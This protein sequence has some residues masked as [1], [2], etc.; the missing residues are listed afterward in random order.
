MIKK[1]ILFSLLAGVLCCAGCSKN[2]DNDV[3]PRENITDWF[4]VRDKPG[5][6]N[7][8]L[9]KVY[10]EHGLAI[11]INDTLGREIEGTDAY[12][13][14]IVHTELFDVG[15]YVFGTYE[16]FDTIRL[17]SDTAA[18]LRAV[19]VIEERVL[20]YLPGEGKYRPHSLLLVESINCIWY[21]NSY[22]Q[23]NYTQPTYSRSLKGMVCGDLLR[24][25][26]MD[27][28]ELAMWAGNILTGKMVVGLM[29]NY[30]KDAEAYFAITDEGRESGTNYDRY[31]WAYET[32]D[33]AKDPE[34]FGFIKWRCQSTRNKIT[35]SKSEDFQEFASAV[36]AF[37]GRE[38]E[39]T[40]KYAN[41]EKVLRKF[42]IMKEIVEKF[43]AT[44]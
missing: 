26:E 11:F 20:P 6:L 22:T 42:E 5:E 12:G 33:L 13:E 30:G 7:Q 25:D 40:A 15:Y 41:Y 38:S 28:D 37:R 3:H 39:F 17:C 4:V 29:E 27:E 8:L 19:K 2:E 9:Y 43:E 31:I 21:Y 44:W 14:P 35:Q 1:Y 23:I 24:L 18:M 10:K 32:E 16:D 36:Y 34:D